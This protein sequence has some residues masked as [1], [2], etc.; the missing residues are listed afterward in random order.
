MPPQHPHKTLFVSSIFILFFLLL[1]SIF[2]IG[3]TLQEKV[4]LEKT[5]TLLTKEKK[6]ETATQTMLK[7]NEKNALKKQQDIIKNVQSNTDLPDIAKA[8]VAYSIKTPTTIPVIEF[9]SN[10]GEYATVSLHQVD[11]AGGS[12]LFLV[13]RNGQWIVV[14]NGNGLPSCTDAT[15]LVTKYA[16]KK[17]FLPCVK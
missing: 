8:A 14:Y 11:A 4:L 3:K 10:D 9:L 1:L 15:A 6:A 12:I 13:K 5:I 2:F 7:E 17:D 16:L